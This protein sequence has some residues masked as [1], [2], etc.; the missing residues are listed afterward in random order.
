MHIGIILQHEENGLY[1][2][3]CYLCPLADAAVTV[4]RATS[5]AVTV[6]LAAS[7]PVVAVAAAPHRLPVVEVVEENMD[8]VA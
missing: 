2:D 1:A 8:Q 7:A 4:E 3:V 6:E 5:A